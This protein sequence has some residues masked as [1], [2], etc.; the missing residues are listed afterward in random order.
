MSFQFIIT[1]RAL[2]KP[3]LNF[4]SHCAPP[5][6]EH[7]GRGTPGK[8]LH[9]GRTERGTEKQVELWKAGGHNGAGR[10]GGCSASRGV[11]ARDRIETEALETQD[12]ILGETA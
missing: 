4:S 7:V 11:A 8:S 12:C 5:S 1:G 10:W 6:R 3:S 2:L 9:A